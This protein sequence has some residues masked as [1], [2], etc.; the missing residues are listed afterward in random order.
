[1]LA[2]IDLHSKQAHSFH[3]T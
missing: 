3:P 2:I 1:M